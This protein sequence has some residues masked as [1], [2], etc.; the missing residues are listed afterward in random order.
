MSDHD[1]ATIID[2]AFR[3]FTHEAAPSV[4]APEVSIVYAAVA[5]QHKV[6]VAGLSVVSALAVVLPVSIYFGLANGSQSP[7]TDVLAS[8]SPSVGASPSPSESPGSRIDRQALT[9]QPIDLP[10]W[11]CGTKNL[12]LADTAGGE[13][14]IWVDALVDVAGAGDTP[15]MT[16]ALIHCQS[17]RGRLSQVVAFQQNAAGKITSLGQVIVT[18]ANVPVIQ[19][20]RPSQAGDVSVIVTSNGQSQIRDFK[21]NGQRFSQISGPT[22]PA[23]PPPSKPPQALADLEVKLSGLTFGPEADGVRTGSITVTVTN[24]STTASAGFSVALDG[25]SVGACPGCPGGFSRLGSSAITIEPNQWA[26]GAARGPLA[27]GGSTTITVSFTLTRAHA[28]YQDRN[29]ISATLTP[30]GG[31]DPKGD[32]NYAESDFT[33]AG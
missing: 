31:K 11:G 19:E 2:N 20:I 1:E 10:G 18:S 4:H 17:V 12:T 14:S 22:D 25:D 21:W 6:R 13:G 16:V 32:N 23:T 27:G 15:P 24:L 7:P 5:H 8:A 3:S 28:F 26:N 29:V 33:V 30:S 9:G